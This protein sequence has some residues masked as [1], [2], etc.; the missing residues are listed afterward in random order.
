MTAPR[1]GHAAVAFLAGALP[2]FAAAIHQA[3][4]EQ[5][6]ALLAG[7]DVLPAEVRVCLDSLMRPAADAVVL[8]FDALRSARGQ[9][10]GDAERGLRLG[11]CRGLIEAAAQRR[12]LDHG[13]SV[14]LNSYASRLAAEAQP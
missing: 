8:A 9:Y 5:R 1:D 14:V 4:A 13:E 3:E 6:A 2:S 12:E 7:R 11:Y 10:L